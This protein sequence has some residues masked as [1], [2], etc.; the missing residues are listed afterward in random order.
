MLVLFALDFSTF[1][2]LSLVLIVCRSRMNHVNTKEEV[3]EAFRV[4]DK[5]GR[6]KEGFWRCFTHFISLSGTG[7]IS[8]DELR[9]ILSE[10]GD[11]MDPNEVCFVSLWLLA[12]MV[13]FSA[14]KSPVRGRR[15]PRRQYLL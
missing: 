12:L 15:Q 1:L 13:C 14:R 5:Q 3:I 2:L 4:F 10:L 7:V 9:Q 8:V 6:P 11:P